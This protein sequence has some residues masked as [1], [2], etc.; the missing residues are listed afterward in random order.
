MIDDTADAESEYGA[1]FHFKPNISLGNSVINLLLLQSEQ[2]QWVGVLR[3]RQLGGEY[4]LRFLTYLDDGSPV[5]VPDPPTY[6]AT[7]G[8]Y[9]NY[10]VIEVQ[11]GAAS[12]PGASD[13]YIKLWVNGGLAGKL[14]GLDNDQKSIGKVWFGLAGGPQ[15]LPGVSGD[16]YLDDFS[17]WSGPAPP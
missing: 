3:L 6:W 13:G 8:P 12:A 17:S 15:G 14:S 10:A 1:Y 11:W 9:L 16:Y 7:I 4:Q 2:G 5:G